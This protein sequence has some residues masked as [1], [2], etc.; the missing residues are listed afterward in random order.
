MKLIRVEV[1]WKNYF[2]ELINKGLFYSGLLFHLHELERDEVVRAY[3]HLAR[4]LHSPT[5]SEFLNESMPPDDALFYFTELGFAKLQYY[6]K[7]VENGIN[8][9]HKVDCGFLE[10]KTEIKAIEKTIDLPELKE[11]D[12]WYKD[13]DQ[14]CIRIW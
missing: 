5:R 7:I 10:Q 4:D 1:Q 12:V 3:E 13:E 6:L 2:G 8:M 14:V 9:L 11:Y